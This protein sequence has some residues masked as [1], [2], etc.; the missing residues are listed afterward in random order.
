MKRINIVMDVI[1]RKLTHQD[2][3]NLLIIGG[4][5]GIGKSTL[6]LH[7]CDYWYNLLYNNCGPELIKNV[8]LS[9]S[10]FITALKNLK[11]YEL[12]IY[13]EAGELSSLR[14]ME[15]FNYAISKAYE[16]IRGDNLF[17]ILILPDVF[18][19][20]PFFSMRRARGYI[21]VYKRG[22]FAYWNKITLR[23]LVEKNKS[24]K[25]KSVWRV[26]PLF[27]DRFFK[28][29]GA[30]KEPYDKKKKE[31]M[32]TIRE[33]LYDKLLIKEQEKYDF[34]KYIFNAKE[35][36]GV[37]KSSEIFECS[38]QTI[39]N[40]YHEFKESRDKEFKIK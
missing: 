6:G 2:W 24:Y 37:T 9:L 35:L 17:T 3:D 32:I 34:L 39:Y 20:N 26:K 40:K 11:R 16:V 14:M 21:H 10:Q 12:I 25:K 18:Y 28:Y 30:L 31:K 7:L 4:D 13:D 1:F 5:E 36:V 33:D 19:V 22:S 27:H 23:N 38:K 15:K 8:A 29:K